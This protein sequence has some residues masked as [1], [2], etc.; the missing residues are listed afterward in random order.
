MAQRAEPRIGTLRGTEEPPPD[1]AGE[2][3]MLRTPTSKIIALGAVL[4]L[5][6]ALLVQNPAPADHTS[7][8]QHGPSFEEMN[9]A[10]PA[11][12]TAESFDLSSLMPGDRGLRG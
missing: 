7:P 2:T 8:V 6:T 10:I 3:A 9:S 12:T 4:S 1:Q 5:G 11:G